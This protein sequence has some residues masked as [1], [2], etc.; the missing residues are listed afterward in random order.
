VQIRITF[1]LSADSSKKRDLRPAAGLALRIPLPLTDDILKNKCMGAQKIKKKS[2]LD[3]TVE[4]AKLMH[5]DPTGIEKEILQAGENLV[6]IFSDPNY[7][8]KRFKKLD[9]QKIETLK[10]AVEDI[11]SGVQTL[12]SS[13]LGLSYKGNE[14][15]SYISPH[16]STPEG[17]VIYSVNWKNIAAFKNWRNEGSETAVNQ[18]DINS[19]IYYL[20]VEISRLLK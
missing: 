8:K 11:S 10:S 19:A 5:E 7:T 1:R 4:L 14:I 12:R 18:D 16:G 15:N 17:T 20:T 2:I 9:Q 6:G 3:T 13:T